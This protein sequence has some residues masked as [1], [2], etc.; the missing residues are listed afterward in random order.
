VREVERRASPKNDCEIDMNFTRKWNL[1]EAMN[2]DLLN[3]KDA[4]ERHS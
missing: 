3:D 2:L 1:K 4:F